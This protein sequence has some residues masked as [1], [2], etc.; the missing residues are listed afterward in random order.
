MNSK[1]SVFKNAQ[2]IICARF[3]NEAAMYEKHGYQLNFRF[4]NS[5]KGNPYLLVSVQLA[6]DSD[7]T[8]IRTRR[9][10]VFVFHAEQLLKDL[11]QHNL[12]SSAVR[13]IEKCLQKDLQHLLKFSIEQYFKRRY[14]FILLHFLTFCRFYS[15]YKEYYN[16]DYSV[17]I[18]IVIILIFLIFGIVRA[19]FQIKFDTFFW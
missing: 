14:N 3:K 1:I 13:R 16:L 6:S 4:K 10:K 11:A 2:G 18:T 8:A 19:Y 15:V 17:I 5:K 7:S 12:Y 9:I